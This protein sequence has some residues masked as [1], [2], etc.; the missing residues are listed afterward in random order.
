[1]L[2]LRVILP[3]SIVPVIP[4]WLNAEKIS[5]ILVDELTLISFTRAFEELYTA[6]A[7]PLEGFAVL[8]PNSP[9]VFDATA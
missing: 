1:M 9:R 6:R 3:S 7:Y 8:M 5:S 4:Y 2:D